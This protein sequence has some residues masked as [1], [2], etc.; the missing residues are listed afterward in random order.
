MVLHLAHPMAARLGRMWAG[1]RP[2]SNIFNNNKKRS[3]ILGI[4]LYGMNKKV[5]YYVIN[6][7]NICFR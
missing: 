3:K 6:T 1:S 7:Q 5:P 2:F 4:F